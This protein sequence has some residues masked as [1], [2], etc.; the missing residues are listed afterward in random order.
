[1]TPG[2]LRLFVG[3]PVTRGRAQELERWTRRHVDPAWR[4]VPASNLHVTLVFLG[5]TPADEVPRIAAALEAAVDGV[6]A[7][8]LRPDP[9]RRFG[10]V[11]ALP[12]RDAAGGVPAG[13]AAAQARLAHALE[14]LEERP[15]TPH[16]TIARA[17]RRA[18]PPLPDAAPPALD[19]Q[20]DEAVAYASEPAGRGVTYR[21]LASVPLKTDVLRTDADGSRESAAPRHPH[22]ADR[23]RGGAPDRGGGPQEGD[24]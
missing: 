10:A 9:A 11:L 24:A 15:W 6:A 4:A 13:L 21:P 17:G 14:R 16:V 20:F 19:L 5:A 12:L 1:M 2:V 18:R 23:G 7:V 3:L 22:R 8:D